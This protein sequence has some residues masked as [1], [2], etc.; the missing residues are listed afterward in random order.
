MS[1]APVIVRAE[2]LCVVRSNSVLINAVS[3]S[4]RAG[5]VMAVLGANGAG[6]STL[7]SALANELTLTSGTLVVNEK[8]LDAYDAESL[9]E[10]RALNAVEPP[11]AFSLTV[12]DYVALGRPFA[13]PDCNGVLAALQECHAAQW[14]NRDAA[15]LSSGELLRVQLARSLYQLG[16]T[17]NAL[18]LLDEP[19]AHLDLA[20]RQFALQLLR[21][22]A[23]DRGWAILFSTHAPRDA[24]LIADRA[25]LLR[26]GET[27]ALG[28]PKYILTPPA[29]KACYGIEVSMP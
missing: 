11:L 8:S 9:A 23:T 17:P 6:K 5:E 26:E 25:L 3:F 29:L 4:L 28:S 2:A 22:V 7:I 20:Q 13:E 18:W 16:E 27:V 24:S 1:N 19:L 15:S 10:L 14:M 21:R 12:F